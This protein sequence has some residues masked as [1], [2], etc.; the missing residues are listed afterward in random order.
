MQNSRILSRS[1]GMSFILFTVTLLAQAQAT[2]TW[3]SGVGDDVNP[4]NRTA[5]CKTFAGAISKTAASGE[6]NCLDPGGFGSVTLTK[7]ITIDCTATL[8]SILGVQTNGIIINIAADGADVPGIVR[9]RGLAINGAGNGINGIRVMAA[10]KVFIENTVI[11]GFTQNGVSI[12]NAAGNTQLSIYHSSIRNITGSGIA[13]SGAGTSEVALGESLI[14]GN[15][16][17]VS[18]RAKAV[19]QMSRNSITFNKVAFAT[20]A[21]GKIL[22]FKDNVIQGNEKN[23]ATTT[24][25]V[26][27]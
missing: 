15:G 13:A 19:V 10:N 17:G 16:T 8:G 6:I 5:P 18:V 21:G 11:D 7:S 22:S 9:I 20:E 2:R 1:F 27:Q 24:G 4:C 26:L 14:S 23:G 25:I 3:V 12:E